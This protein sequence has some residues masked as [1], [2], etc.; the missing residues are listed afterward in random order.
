M[1]TK[2]TMILIIAMLFLLNCNHSPLQP[3]KGSLNVRLIWPGQ[4]SN[5][6]LESIKQTGDP[7]TIKV[8]LNPG[9]RE[10]SFNYSAGSG[11]ISDLKP[12]SY[13]ITVEALD[14]DENITHSGSQS[15]IVVEAGKET[16]V[17]ITLA[18]LTPRLTTPSNGSITNDN[19]PTFDWSDVNAASVYELEVDNDSSFSNPEIDE[20]NLSSSSYTA[21]SPL[22]DGIYYW[23]VRCRDSY[24]NWGS[25]SDVWGF[26]IS[27]TAPIAYF[28]I[29]P[30][31]GNTDTQFSFDASECS[32][33]EDAISQ[34]EVR[35]DWENDGT[36]D[37]NYSTTKTT[38]HQYTAESSYTVKLEVKDTGGL[39]NSTTRQILVTNNITD[40]DGN[41][42]R[43]VKIGDQWWMAEN[44]KVTHYRNGDAI[45]NVTD[46]YEWWF[47]LTTGAYCNYDNN[48]N[49]VT[50]YSRLYNWY[51]VNDSRNIAPEGW[52][53]PA[54][55][56]WQTL[57]D[58][59]G[60]KN[61]AGG[62]MKESGTAHWDRPNTGAT[63]ESGFSALPSGIRSQNFASMGTWTWF[64]SSSMYIGNYAWSWDLT[65]DQ[66]RIRQTYNL[67]RHGFSVRCVKD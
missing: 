22:S 64:W 62:K 61:G 6:L 31:S 20:D 40:I 34:L 36:W 51:A 26:T 4:N 3:N 47:N 16:S 44:L 32:D 30:S 10:Y 5:N 65:Y 42:Y 11:Q 18:D 49:N 43:T 58:Y 54:D 23:R 56:E 19:T 55:A 13:D 12:G 48:V 2:I 41:T 57:V 63:N 25:F 59:L 28:T 67:E 21:T 27:N 7:I 8:T 24:G 66:S 53:V 50:T 38:T 39:T 29:D 14:A 33:N 45:P 17:S 35:W 52:H 1:R 46:G 9:A 60:G 15:G 37:T